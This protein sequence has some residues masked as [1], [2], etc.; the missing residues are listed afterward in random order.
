MRV[1]DL[2]SQS[3]QAIQELKEARD[4]IQCLSVGPTE[5]ISGSVDGHVRTYDLRMGELRSDYLGHPVTSITPTTDGQTLLVSTL[6]GRIRLLDR[7]DGRVLNT[8]AGHV[9]RSYRTR[10]GFGHAE[11]SVL[12]GDEDGRIWAWDLVDATTIA[13][14]PPP[15]AHNK[16]VTWLEQRPNDSNQLVSASADGTIK[17]W[18]NAARES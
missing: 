11:A 10:S 17:V 16:V 15:K 5:I 2:K 4:A 12:S 8:F 6:D 1:W 13:P 14:D 7:A 9:N 18:Q 3:R